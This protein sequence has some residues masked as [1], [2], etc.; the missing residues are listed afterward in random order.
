MKRSERIY[1]YI[2][3]Q[4]AQLPADKLTGQIGLDAQEIAD[5]LDILRN[6]VS[7]E[8]NELHRQDKIVKFTGRPVRYFDRETLAALLNVDLDQGPYQF[9][10]IEECRHLFGAGGQD[11]NPFA[12]LIGAD[13]SLKRQVE[14]GKAAIL[15]PP[16][17]L[18]TLIVGQTGVGKTLFAHMMFAYGKA[19]KKFGEEAPFITFNCADYYNNPQLLISH[20]FGHIKGA[21]TGADTAKAGLVEA[22]DGGVLFLDEIHRLPPEGQEMIFY[23][24]DTG[25]FNRLGETTRSRRAK[26]LIIGATTEDPNSALTK[27]FVRRIPNIITI[28]PLA[29]RTLEEKLDILKLLFMEEAQRVKKPIRISVEAV[30]ALIGSIGTGNV[31]QLKSNIKLLCAQAFLNGIDNPSFIEA[32]FRMLPASVRDGLLTLSANRQALAELTQYVSEPLL[33]SP[34]GGK[35]KLA[36]EG[37]KEGFNLYQVVENKVALLKGEGISDELIKQIVATDVNVYVKDLY[38]KKHSVNMTTRERLLKIVDETLVDFSEQVSLYVQKRMNRSYRDRF[39][40]AFSLHLSAFLKR[41]KSKESIPYTE[42]EGALP[43]DSE[44]MRVAEEIG[45]LIEEHYNIVVPQAEIEYI[46][47]LIESANDD[48]LEEK[49]IILVATHGRNTASSMV[50]VAKRLFSSADTDIIAIDMPLEVN[51]QDILAQT[52]AMLRGM[53]CQKGVLILADMG[54][55]CNIGAS[56]SEQLKIPVRT[57]DMVSTPLIL[58]AM[59]K[60]DIA[61]MDLDSIY[62][63]LRSFK[64]YEAVDTHEE[65]LN[66]QNAIVTICSSGHGAAMKIKALVEDVLRH[67]GRIIEVIPVGVLHLEERLTEIAAEYHIVAA[68]GMK[69]PAMNV[70]FIPL[71]QLIDGEGEHILMEL[72]AG[73]GTHIMSPVT[74]KGKNNMVVQR[75]C[76][77]SL[78]RFLT[79][80]NPAKVMSVLLDFDR[81]LEKELHLNLSNPL[82]VRL[83]VHCG[84]AL[85]RVVTRSP[86]VYKDDKSA[87][88]EKKIIALKKAAQIFDET[89]KLRFDED[90]YYFMA[91]ML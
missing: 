1:T 53:E 38:N 33:V 11:E 26:V 58:E 24:M 52:A 64:G 14:Q 20:V 43:Q 66:T 82:R 45:G 28:K 68:V 83:L 10:D 22:A 30:K 90:E 29:E 39:L 63:S 9:R 78:Q 65:P 51:P 86:L 87:V 57:L 89:L 15:Y 6:N 19:M 5:K 84:C 4:S 69:K 31:G 60:V 55:L 41:V 46:A 80:L 42:I 27:T 70:P 35:F 16:D 32:D 71:E 40:Y 67:A 8:L 25:T 48:E 62:E 74:G 73:S 18:H 44:Y 12:R 23:F 61:G 77:E 3:E 79:F 47:L 2:K 59:R 56:L 34:P 81:Q 36:D 13:K 76:E 88:D 21:F 49:I 91:N 85:E 17:G 7:K 72:V 37:S 54:S 50:E 75:L